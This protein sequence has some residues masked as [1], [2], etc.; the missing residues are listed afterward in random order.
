M[1]LNPGQ[2]VHNRYRIARLLGK[3]G[4]GAVYRAWDLNLNVPVAIKE[5]VPQ[6]GLDPHTLAQLR[7]QF[8]QEARTLA[9]L[10]H[11]HLPRVT[12]FFEWGGCSFLVMDFVEG[13]SLD[14][15]VRRQ[16]PLPPAQV[17]R[18]GLQLLDALAYCHA[19]NVLHRDIK[20]QN[21]II[22][23]DGGAVLVDFGLVKL[24]DPRRPETQHIVRGMGT[25][26]FASPEHFHLGGQHTSPRSDLYS[27]GATLYYALTG[28]E[29]P[30]AMDRW[31]HQVPLIPPRGSSIPPQLTAVILRAME[32]DPN[33]RFADARQ[34]QAALQQAVG[35]GPVHIQQ[36]VAPPPVPGSGPGARPHPVPLP[37]DAR[38]PLEMATGTVM[39]LIGVLAIQVLLFAPWMTPALYFGRSLSALVLG[40]L[41]WFIGD[42]IFQALARP[43]ATAAQAPSRRPT[44]R[45]VAF[46]RSL[47]RRLTT[48]QQIALL[49][50]LLVIVVLLAWLLAPAV[51]RMPFVVNYVSFYAPIAPL[52][53]AAVGRRPGRAGLAHVLAVTLGSAVAATRVFT[54]VGIGELFLA[55]LAGGLLMEGAAFL[56][57]RTVIK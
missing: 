31:A 25:Y 6:P 43:E 19:R 49:A 2:I 5:M 4:M 56:A 1:P 57:E 29:P 55:A 24:W 51:A 17:A 12:D 21:I 54:D 3:G 15:I 32:L 18:W 44:Q 39:A 16:G 36:P 52:V 42:L 40:A 46:T 33:R 8:H 34:M 53:Y 45:L 23:P 48:G 27:L 20:P 28:Q 50:A 35:S 13:E 41:G 47:T 26:E 7:A 14:Q 11:P 10:S 38:W 37:R 22:R 9:A 30:S